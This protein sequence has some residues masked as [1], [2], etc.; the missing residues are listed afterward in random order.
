MKQ[1]RVSKQAAD[2][3]VRAPIK[4]TVFEVIQELTKLTK[5]DNLVLAAFRDIFDSHKVTALRSLAP[6]RVVPSDRPSYG[7]VH[8]QSSW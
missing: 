1:K 2:R 4:T 8:R 5:N 3:R 7:R 6:V